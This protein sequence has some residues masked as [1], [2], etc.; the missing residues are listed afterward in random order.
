MISFVLSLLLTVSCYAYDENLAIYCVNLV[1]STYCVSSVDDWV[2]KTCEPSIILDYVVENSGSKAI[3]GYD[4][5]TNTIF[6]SFR[7]SSN[8]H[9]WIEN[10]QIHQIAPYNDSSIKIE[11]GFFK[12]YNFIKSEIFINL[13]E[14]TDKYNTNRLLITGHSLGGAMATIMT[15]EIFL[16]G[17]MY[18]VNYL[19]TFGSPRVGNSEF[20][21][22][23]NK[24]KVTSY[25]ITHYY[26]MVPHVPEEFLKY[27]HISNEIWYNED[28]SKFKICNDYLSED[29]SCS[30]SCGPV[31]CTSTSDHLTYLNMSMGNDNDSSCY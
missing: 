5:M 22:D 19:I 28:N 17:N 18:N 13:H 3:Q 24:Y 4:N 1:Q 8:I 26:D 25:R 7:G 20:V 11:E 16:L 14:L 27:S 12:A 2:Y 9:N 6:T 29:N 23:F 30:N 31:H 10:I 15:Y 21:K